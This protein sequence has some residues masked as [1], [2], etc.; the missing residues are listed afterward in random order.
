MAVSAEMTNRVDMVEP[1]YEAPG[2]M[3][4]W[5][6]ANGVRFEWS[7]NWLM[8]L[9]KSRSITE[10]EMHLLLKLP[11]KNKGEMELIFYKSKNGEVCMV[12]E[13][14]PEPSFEQ[15]LLRKLPFL[16][17][18]GSGESVTGTGLYDVKHVL[19]NFDQVWTFVG[20]EGGSVITSDVNGYFSGPGD[21]GKMR[22]GIEPLVA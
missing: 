10:T 4:N 11:N 3:E 12:G 6:E 7:R 22:E 1:N 8:R 18:K 17:K 9:L 20:G 16:R 5:F 15:G 13:S 2:E 19:L 14:R 21:L